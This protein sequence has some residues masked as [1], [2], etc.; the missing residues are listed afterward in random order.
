M[1]SLRQ[2]E[3]TNSAGWSILVSDKPYFDSG[4]EFQRT[5]K[6]RRVDL[7]TPRGKALFD[8]AMYAMNMAYKVDVID[9]NGTRCDDF[10]ELD[11]KRQPSS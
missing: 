11:V 8:L 1:S 7:G 5:D 6:G 2:F 10:D 9:N 4:A 3:E